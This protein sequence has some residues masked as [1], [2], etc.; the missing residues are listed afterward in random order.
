MYVEYDTYANMSFLRKNKVMHE[1]TPE[2]RAE[3]VR[4]HISRFLERSRGQLNEEQTRV[5]EDI[6]TRYPDIKE[7]TEHRMLVLFPLDLLRQFH[8][9]MFKNSGDIPNP[10]ARLIAIATPPNADDE[11]RAALDDLATL[12]ASEL[13]EKRPDLPELLGR[14]FDTLPA[15]IWELIDDEDVAL[16][17]SRARALS[18]M[19]RRSAAPPPPPPPC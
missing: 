4:T 3:L 7:Y 5:L 6:L 9:E 16:A 11:F 15:N 8:M 17:A 1:I 2:N 14:Y 10:L 12:P 13:R 19:R 18:E